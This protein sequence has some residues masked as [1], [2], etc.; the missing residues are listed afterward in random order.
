LMREAVVVLPP[1]SRSKEDVERRDLLSPLDFEA[2]L[3]PLAVLVY[4]RV[5]DVNEW[6]VA[7]EKAVS[8]RENV[9]FE[10]ALERSVL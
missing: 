10:P 8:S 7:V 6:L 9:A 1:D 4:H 3:N 2:L 5:N